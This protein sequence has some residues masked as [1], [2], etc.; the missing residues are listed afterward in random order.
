MKILLLEDNVSLA[1]IIK[2]MFEE[3]G[4][5]VD[6]F[7]DGQEALYEI[8]NG[9][10]CFILDINVP[11]LNG[12]NLLKEIRSRDKTTPAIIISSN[13]EFETVKKAY[14]SGCNDF[15]KKPFYIYELEC[16]VDLLCNKEEELIFCN[17]FHFN[18][19]EEILYDENKNSIKLTQKE[20]R[21]LNLLCKTPN[22]A[23][24][25][26]TIEQYVWEGEIVGISGIRSLIKRVRSKVCKE[27]IQT[28]NYGYKL[29]TS[30]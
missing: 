16:K 11:S 25:L 29:I 20:K 22:T 14:S 2:E 7:Q 1:E 26:D 5:I 12:L 9:Y 28:E 3:K 21:L 15:L 6:W 10:D 4:L 27:F 24:S 17:D 30:K 18:I 13:I 8:I 19:K 23:V